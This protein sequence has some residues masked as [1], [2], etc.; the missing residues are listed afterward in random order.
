MKSVNWE[1]HIVDIS[2]KQNNDEW[3]LGINPR[4]LLPVLIHDGNRSI[5]KGRTVDFEF[6]T[7][8]ELFE[9]FE[10]GIK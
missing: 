2:K 4:G 7:P 5:V 3:F 8:E 6:P 9:D 10:D 1:S